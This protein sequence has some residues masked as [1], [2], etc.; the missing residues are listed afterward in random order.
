MAGSNSKSFRER[1]AQE[2]G[3][4]GLTAFD[5]TNVVLDALAGEAVGQFLK[6]VI[7]VRSTFAGRQSPISFDAN[8]DTFRVTSFSKGGSTLTGTSTRH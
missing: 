3:F 7:R 2:P 5:A 8:G 1:F 4:A 6:Q